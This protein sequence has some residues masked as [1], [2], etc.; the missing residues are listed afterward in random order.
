MFLPLTAYNVRCSWVSYVQGTSKVRGENNKRSTQKSLLPIPNLA[1]QKERSRNGG[2]VQPH[3][4]LAAC[5]VVLSNPI[6]DV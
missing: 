5:T 3:A 1:G 2:L 6:T 4:E